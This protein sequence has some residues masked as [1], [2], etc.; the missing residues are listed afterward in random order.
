MERED[1]SASWPSVHHVFRPYVPIPSCSAPAAR[2]FRC[3]KRVPLAS[4]LES[5][6]FLSIVSYAKY[7]HVLKLAK[8]RAAGDALYQI[9]ILCCGQAKNPIN[10]RM[11][12]GR[13]IR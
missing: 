10:G 3:Q 13:N 2:V 5:D 6:Q 12:N 8:S 9:L 11:V 7:A 1:I 4:A